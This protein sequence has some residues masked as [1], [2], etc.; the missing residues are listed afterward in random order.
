MRRVILLLPLALSACMGTATQGL[1]PAFAPVAALAPP[2]APA[3]GAIFQ[4]SAGYA[5]LTSGQR[6]AKIGDM[7]T[8]ELV[9]RTTATKA[10]SAQ[11][12]RDGSIG[13]TPPITG[14]LDFIKPSDLNMGG[15]QSFKGSGTASQSNQLS[16]E[17]TVVVAAVN[18]NG[19]MVV[20]GEKRVTLNRGDEYIRLSGIVRTA[21]ISADNRLLSNRVADAR[22]TY[23][24]EG[25]LA[26]AS[27]QGWLSRFF[28]AVSPF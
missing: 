3:N 7:L 27:K 5:A 2:P 16:G 24:G 20:R 19:T 21:D 15:K 22:I 8:I 14:P 4:A 6:A 23:S 12:G 10:N 17:I 1:D 13:V 18:A 26:R 11:T 25:E 9:E 28:S